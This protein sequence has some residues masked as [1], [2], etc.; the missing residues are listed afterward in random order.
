MT[1]LHAARTITPADVTL[2]ATIH[3]DITWLLAE[4]A[5]PQAQ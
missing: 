5:A 3:I 1:N 2:P 4:P